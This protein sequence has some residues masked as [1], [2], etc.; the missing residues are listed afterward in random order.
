MLDSKSKS[1]ALA[2]NEQST[3]FG[4]SLSYPQAIK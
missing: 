3:N 4:A 1:R 2:P